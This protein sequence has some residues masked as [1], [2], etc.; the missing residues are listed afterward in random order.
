MPATGWP[1]WVQYI[2]MPISGAIIAYDSILFLLGVI[3]ENDRLYSEKEEEL[4]VLHVKK[5]K[6]KKGGAH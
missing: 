3:D 6:T 1:R 5:E 2:S 4:Q